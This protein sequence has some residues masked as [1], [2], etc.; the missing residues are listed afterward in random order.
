MSTFKEDFLQYVWQFQYFDKNALQTT[1]GHTINIIKPGLL[2]KDSGPDFTQSHIQ[3]GAIK[4]VGDVEIHYKSSDWNKHNHQIDEAYNKVILHVVWEKDADI[5]HINGDEIPCL[6]LKSR[7]DKA[8]ILNYEQII[9]STQNFPCTPFK[10]KIESIKWTAQLE[11]AIVQ[12]LERKSEMALALYTQYQNWEQVAYMSFCQALGSKI[13]NDAF[14]QLSTILPLKYLLKHRNNLMQLEALLLGCAGFL[15]QNKEVDNYVTELRK[16]FA[17]LQHKYNLNTMNASAW[18]FFRLR[19]TAFPT[20]RL[21]QLA[22]ILH[23]HIGFFNFIH[24]YQQPLELYFANLQ[25]SPYWET[26][27]DLAKPFSKT[28][29]GF[30]DEFI[31]GLQINAFVPLLFAIGTQNEDY[32]QRQFAMELLQTLSF[33]DNVVTR[34]WKEFKFETKSAYDSQALIEQFTQFCSAK[35]CLHCVIGHSILNKR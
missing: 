23:Q 8:L 19:P 6:E 26:H 10:D 30:G 25:L 3:F 14:L 1:D 2:N 27:Y 12:R 13:N 31:R 11:T 4:W 18:K 24:S 35:K 33:E 17:F 7:I 28:N 29:K 34:E 21:A 9:K 16:E 20:Y 22:S 5:K 15:H 32:E